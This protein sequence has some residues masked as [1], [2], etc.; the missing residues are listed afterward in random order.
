MMAGGEGLFSENTSKVGSPQINKLMELCRVEGG[1]C[2]LLQQRKSEKTP[3]I[4]E[5][6]SPIPTLTPFDLL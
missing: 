4:T 1:G 5:K 2:L 6:R 3:A